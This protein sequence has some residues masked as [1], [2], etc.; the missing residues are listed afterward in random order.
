MLANSQMRSRTVTTSRDC[1]RVFPAPVGSSR[2]GEEKGMSFL[3]CRDHFWQ[4][5]GTGTLGSQRPRRQRCSW[6]FPL[7][8]H[9][10]RERLDL[11]REEEVA[12]LEQEVSSSALRAAAHLHLAESASTWVAREGPRASA[13]VGVL[14]VLQHEL[15]DEDALARELHTELLRI[16]C[17]VAELWRGCPASAAPSALQA[18]PSLAG[19]RP[20]SAEERSGEHVG[21]GHGTP[22]EQAAIQPPRSGERSVTL[23]VG[24]LE[25]VWHTFLLSIRR[26]DQQRAELNEVIQRASSIPEDVAQ[27]HLLFQLAAEKLRSPGTLRS[28]HAEACALSSSWPSPAPARQYRRVRQ[29]NVAST[30]PSCHCGSDSPCRVASGDEGR[31]RPV[32]ARRLYQQRAGLHRLVREERATRDGRLRGSGLPDP[33]HH[34]HGALGSGVTPAEPALSNDVLVPQQPHMHVPGSMELAAL[35]GLPDASAFDGSSSTSNVLNGVVVA[36]A[37]GL[38]PPLSALAL[39]RRARTLR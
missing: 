5:D 6:D 18:G 22:Q 31:A 29:Q 32:S 11:I 16:K 8:V 39:V 30:H 25:R 10:K 36:A 37:A 33:S 17:S 27:Q 14:R 1:G 7:A 4:A 2:N 38:F 35:G 13:D 28:R 3:G 20:S 19:Q 21:G 23:A 9:E 15:S 34:A 24:S 12:L 26:L